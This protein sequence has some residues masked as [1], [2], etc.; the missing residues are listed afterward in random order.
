MSTEPHFNVIISACW[1]LLHKSWR[2]VEGT[3]SVKWTTALAIPER[4][5]GVKYV[6]VS[7]C[8]GSVTK[9]VIANIRRDWYGDMVVN[10][11]AGTK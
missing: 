4:I 11:C 1:R 5:I 3:A 6:C 9:V 7:L 2:V 8:A 10:V